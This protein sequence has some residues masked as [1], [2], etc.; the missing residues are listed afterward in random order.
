MGIVFDHIY[1]KINCFSI[2]RK[3][4][5][6]FVFTFICLVAWS[7]PPVD[8]KV[9]ENNAVNKIKNQT[10]WE[11]K[12]NGDIPDPA[13]IKTS[14]TLYNSS[15]DVTEVTTYN[16]KGL[17]M[18]V[19]RYRYDKAGNKIEYSRY[20]GGNES[21]VAYQKISR[22]NDNNNVVEENGFDGVEKFSNRYTYDAQGN[23]SEILYQKNGML[24]ERRVFR[25]DGLKT[26]VSIYNSAGKMISKLLLTYDSKNNLTEET[27]YGMNQ[28][29]IEKKI[30]DYDEKKNLRSESKYKLNKMTLRTTYNYSPD[31]DLLE[32][33]EEGPE[34]GKYVKKSFAYG[35]RGLVAE[36]KWRRRSNEDF[37]SIT[38]QYDARG[39]C[40]QSITFYPATNYRA[41]TKYSYEFY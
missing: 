7:Q 30:F 15:G 28:D 12:Y 29:I 38:H 19:E 22:Y 26:H 25:K 20:T 4:F 13:G 18:N 27:V 34:G 11:H 8:K 37:N 10:S 16:P 3:Q 23:L 24:K 5:F 41:L 17:V 14:V 32:I 35:T 40:L 39:I 33:T 9:R 2:M 21:Q 1:E 31:G 36:I 6:C